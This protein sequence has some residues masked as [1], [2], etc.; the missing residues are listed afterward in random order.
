ELFI[1]YLG[2]NN[3]LAVPFAAL[4]GIPIYASHG[5]VV[6]II[7]VLL[8]KGVPVG[9]AL[10]ALMSITAIS[11]PEM[12]MLKKVFSYKL[13]ILFISFLLISFV[14]TGYIIN[15]L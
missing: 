5:G 7:Q 6:P 9:T 12:V 13:L 2:I 3:P 1:K 15:M 11:L 8:L 10:V 4:I 14:I